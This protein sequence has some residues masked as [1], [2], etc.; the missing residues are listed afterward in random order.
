MKALMAVVMAAFL[1]A[2]CAAFDAIP[3]SV[4]AKLTVQQATMRVIDE[5]VP[6]AERVIHLTEEIGG[7]V[8]DERVTVAAVDDYLRSQID[9]DQ[10]SL[11][12]AQLVDMLLDE[13]R[14]RFE[15]R[16]GDGVLAEDDKVVIT[17]LLGWVADSAAL[18]VLTRG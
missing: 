17:T 16:L 13:V 15:E 14:F 11:A 2:G 18:V 5:D 3:E 1:M 9:W 6:R 10:L 12:D 7:Y 4:G 8:Q